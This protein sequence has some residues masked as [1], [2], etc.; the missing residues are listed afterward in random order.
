[1]S[2]QPI[3]VLTARTAQRGATLI[4]VMIIMVLITL[5]GLTAMRMGVSSLALA[6]NSQVT[7]LVFQSSDAGLQA[8]LKRI[9]SDTTVA[10]ATGVLSDAV[11]NPGKEYLF[12][13]TPKTTPGADTL[14][15]TSGACDVTVANNFMS[16]RSAV[17]VQVTVQAKD[18]DKAL[19]AQYGTDA[20]AA[21]QA[22][23]TVMVYSTAVLPGLGSAS[24]AT[25][26]GCLSKTNDESVNR[27]Q[28]PTPVNMDPTVT[29]VTDCLTDAGAVFNS[30]ADERV[31]TTG[32]SLGGGDG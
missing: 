18:L 5:L 6:T 4:T 31:L 24:N 9:S 14:P 11:E 27:N 13:L 20:S 22:G 23:Y 32:L 2:E 10:V 1:M 30:Q 26:N 25:I 3:P 17:A 29:T 12:C 16:A 8:M 28:P 15:F 19:S 7:N 21:P